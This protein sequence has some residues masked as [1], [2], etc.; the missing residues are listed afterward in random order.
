MRALAAVP[1]LVLVLAA[2][3][4]HAASLSSGVPVWQPV[5]SVVQDVLADAS[6]EARSAK[7]T[8]LG[9]ASEAGL[10]PLPL[11]VPAPAEDPDAS[12]LPD[13]PD[14]LVGV[15]DVGVPGAPDVLGPIVVG[16]P[17]PDAGAEPDL[18]LPGG[19][20]L[21]SLLDRA[22]KPT[23]LALV[24]PVSV[25]PDEP[26]AEPAGPLWSQ[27]WAADLAERL[28]FG[29]AFQAWLGSLLSNAAGWYDGMPAEARQALAL[30][31]G[32]V[33]SG[34]ALAGL[35]LTGFRHVDRANLLAHTF[36]HQVLETVRQQPGI[37][38]REVARR[39]DLTPNNAAYHLRVLERHGLL[40][41]ERLH[42][43]RVYFPAAGPEARRKFLAESLLRLASRARV[44]AAVAA[45]PAPNQTRIAA[46]TGQHQGAVGWHLRLLMEAGLVA[47]ERTSRE[48]RY[49]LTALGSELAP[50]A[51][52]QPAPPVPGHIA[53]PE[54]SVGR[55]AAA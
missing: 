41:S 51:S 22:E 34:L 3:S 53:V 42:G 29:N 13:S 10:T 24:N 52:A 48:C 54:G 49:R 2:G 7:A 19:P 28:G 47:E 1:V 12:A 8:A 37:H 44:L 14:Q 40:R 46:L 27:A 20:L 16:P 4:V 23:E 17:A 39:L 55:G 30:V 50:D 21:G 31:G 26:V 33:A 5:R 45:T 6:A 9:L 43:K 18:A 11:P 25:T 32:A 38:L 15:P 36:R 35:F